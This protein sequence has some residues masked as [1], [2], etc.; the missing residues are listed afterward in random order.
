MQ[1]TVDGKLVEAV[2]VP[3]SEV[4]NLEDGSVVHLKQ[5]YS[6][7]AHVFKTFD[8]LKA[9]PKAPVKTANIAVKTANIAPIKAVKTSLLEEVKEEVKKLAHEAEEL[10]EKVAKGE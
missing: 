3:G 2:N 6:A 10:V 7:G 9:A 5:D 8:V 4:W 1:I